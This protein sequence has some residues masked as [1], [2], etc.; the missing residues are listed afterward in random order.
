MKQSWFV[1]ASMAGLVLG[2]SVI[3][4]EKDTSPPK[5]EKGQQGGGSF[6][7]HSFKDGKE[8]PISKPV[9]RQEPGKPPVIIYPGSRQSSKVVYKPN[10]EGY[11]IDQGA[12]WQGK[13]AYFAITTSILLLTDTKTG[14]VLWATGTSA[15]W[16]TITFV[17]VAKANE[18]AKW[19]VAVRS[20]EYPGY[21][22]THDLETGR[23]LELTGGPA[24]P[25]GKTVTPRKVWSDSAG[26][27]KE[28]LYR[29]V[30]SAE[31]WTQLRQ[32]LYGG[33]PKDIPSASDID[34]TKEML[35]ICY[36]GK[37]SQCRGLNPELVVEND[38]RVVVRLS[39]S[40][41]QFFSLNGMTVDDIPVEHPYGLIVLPKRVGKVHILERNTQHYLGGPPFWKEFNRVTLPR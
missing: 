28:K 2:A 31:E 9:I 5:Q 34:F 6:S 8:V 7:S 19:A 38:D 41:Y 13:T 12:E 18:T 17:N 33:Q 11:A 10:G 32:E 26:V 37:T 23:K 40:T 35:L 29:L 15:F 20:T 3:A 22:Q 30:G 1:I 25:A 16:D 4:Q 39:E 21:Q 36:Q 24:P 14:D 27:R